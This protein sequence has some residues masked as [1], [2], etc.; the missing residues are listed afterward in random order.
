VTE[1]NLPPL[2]D[3]PANPTDGKCR[4][5][6]VKNGET[7]D[8]IAKQYKISLEQILKYNQARGVNCNPLGLNTRLCVS[9]GTYP[10][11]APVQNDPNA[12]CI[13]QVA[14]SV[15]YYN[16][17]TIAAAYDISI[18]DIDNW[19][20]KTWQFKG[21]E[22]GV[23]LDQKICISQGTPASPPIL[24][25]DKVQCGAQHP[26]PSKRECPLRACCSKFGWC[27]TTPHFC[28]KV[29]GAPGLGCQSNCEIG[30]PASSKVC[31][32]KMNKAVGYYESWASGRD[33]DCFPLEPE[34]ID[35]SK[36]THIHY[37]FAVVTPDFRLDM[38]QEHERVRLRKFKLLKA[39]KPS[40]KLIISVGGW[41]FNNPA[42]AHLFTNMVATR[43]SRRRFI[44]SV[45]VFLNTY[46]LDGFD[47][48]WEYPT[49][50]ERG[51]REQD[52]ENYLAL[53]KE[54]RETPSFGSFSLSIAAPASYWYL[55]GYKIAEM[56]EYL[57][58]IVYMV[59]LT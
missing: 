59:N 33:K 44:D 12:P 8:I 35:V 49:A 34:D 30:V 52:P 2:P 47:M 32:S 17:A 42:T 10:S 38:A 13:Y 57:D 5:H 26:D 41:T 25:L 31:S 27:G 6:D 43:E 51:G 22:N 39:K 36:W 56:S 45:V 21:C 4:Y 37:S 50:P 18:R 53:M 23:D 20:Q 15:T 1:G 16:C 14:D 40:L 29:E 46:G 11:R 24:P 28:E 55:R 58:Y 19:N 48:D 3:P 54:F 9:L 7:C